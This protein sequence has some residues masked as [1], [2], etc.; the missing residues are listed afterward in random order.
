M[1]GLK[2]EAKVEFWKRDETFLTCIILK[3]HF[4][5]I[6]ISSGK[7]RNLRPNPVRF[8]KFRKTV[9][10]RFLCMLEIELVCQIV[11]V[12][13]ISRDSFTYVVLT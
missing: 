2:K 1:Y 9:K 6:N 5:T 3:C 11:V 12:R 13:S 8:V 4:V 10:Y 7:T